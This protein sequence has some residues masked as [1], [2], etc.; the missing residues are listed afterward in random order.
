MP[1]SAEGLGFNF[2][3]PGGESD[4]TFG[5]PSSC[6]SGWL[7]PFQHP[8]YSRV[9]MTPLSP[10]LWFPLASPRSHSL[11]CHVSPFSFHATLQLL[12]FASLSALPAPS[13]HHCCRWQKGVNKNQC[14]TE[15][16][17]AINCLVFSRMLVAFWF[18]SWTNTR[19]YFIQSLQ[20]SRLLF[21]QI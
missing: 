18:N 1:R 11:F 4:G 20:A 2:R 3:G 14:V 13:W 17:K 15:T 10:R 12:P 9:L 5:H 6:G 21:L 7:S 8:P 19:A 16:W